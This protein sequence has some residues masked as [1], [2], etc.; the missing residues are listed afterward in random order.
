MLN[1]FCSNNTQPQRRQSGN[2]TYVHSRDVRTPRLGGVT[3]TTFP[4][5][6]L[7]FNLSSRMAP[8]P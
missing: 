3:N 1:Q 7:R 2:E 8:S 5:E 4:V 6:N